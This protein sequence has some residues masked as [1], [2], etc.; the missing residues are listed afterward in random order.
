M[1]TKEKLNEVE[2][3]YAKVTQYSAVQSYLLN[4]FLYIVQNYNYI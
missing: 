4:I 1:F 3:K 2:K